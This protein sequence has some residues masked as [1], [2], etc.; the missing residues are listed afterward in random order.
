[1]EGDPKKAVL[2]K[3]QPEG[4]FEGSGRCGDY[5]GIVEASFL[6]RAR[7]SSVAEDLTVRSPRY[8]V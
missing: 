8:Q 6:G 5:D 2:D 7:N 1:M 3:S 4:K